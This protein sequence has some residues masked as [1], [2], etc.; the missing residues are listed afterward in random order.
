MAL[1]LLNHT[2][3]IQKMSKTNQSIMRT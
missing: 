1:T 2:Y 3:R